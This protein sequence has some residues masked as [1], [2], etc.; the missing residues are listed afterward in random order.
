MDQVIA[1]DAHHLRGSSLGRK[2]GALQEHEWL[3]ALKAAGFKDKSSTVS[4]LDLTGQFVDHLGVDRVRRYV[5]AFV[6]GLLDPAMSG[7]FLNR[8]MIGA[9]REYPAYVSYGLYVGRKA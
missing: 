9:W 6:R 1:A 8:R 5:S 2:M 7:P 4:K 3:A